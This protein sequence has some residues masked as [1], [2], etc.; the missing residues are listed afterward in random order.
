MQYQLKKSEIAPSAERKDL[1]PLV[2]LAVM[3]LWFCH[4]IVFS[5]KI[6]FFRDLATYFYPIKFSVAEAFRAGELP[7]WDRHMAT[8]FPIIAEFQSAVFYPPSISFYLLP[9]FAALRLTFVF[10]YALAASGAYILLRS[11]KSPAWVALI[12]AVLFA[13]GGTTVSLTNLLN[14]FQSAVW[15]PWII[16]FWERTLTSRRIKDTIVFAC[17][18]LCQLLGGSP[19]IFLLSLGLV[20]LDTLRL[21]RENQIQN[22]FHA[23]MVLL[24]AGLIIAGLGMVQLLPTAELAMQSRR[25]QAIP[26]GEA[27]AWSLQPSSLIGLL[28][29]TLEADTSLS[30]GVR[31]LLTDGVPFLLSHYMGVFGVLGFF[32]WFWTAPTKERVIV[33]AL[34]IISLV[35]A[36]G[37]HTPVYPLFY[38]WAP[39]LRILRFPEKYFYLTFALLIFAILRGLCRTTNGDKSRAPWMF[40]S[41]IFAGWL[42][43]YLS[44]RSHPVWLARMLHPAGPSLTEIN[45]A[46]LAAILVVLEKQVA[47]SLALLA[48]LFLQ[49]RDLLR[50]VLFQCLLVSTVFFDL[51]SANQPLHFL[52]DEKLIQNVSRVIEKPPVDPARLFY[53]P[54]GNNLHPAFMR[55]IGNPTYEKATEI[56]FNNLLPNAGLLYGFDY[57]QDIDALGR[58]SYTDLLNFINDLPADRRGKLLSALNVKYVIAFHDLDVKGLKLLREFPEHYSRMYEVSGSV[59]RA[60]LVGR[61]I[62]DVDPMNT[63]RR[64][65]SDEFDPRREVVLNAPTHQAREGTIDGETKITH[66]GNQNVQIEARVDQ[67]GVLVLTDAFY[68]G[69]K[70]FVDGTEQRV[71]RANYLFRAVELGA[72]NHHVEFVYDPLSFK[73]G[74]IISLVTAG[75]VIS[76]SLASLVQRRKRCRQLADAVSTEPAH[77]ILD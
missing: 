77:A 24:G 40:A 52:R 25:D 17:A 45:P 15:L 74:W 33:M 36:F 5:G 14:H 31:L 72:G 54:P 35:L 43:V 10:H 66:Y 70:V 44:F 67:P 61:T 50:P 41:M 18:A 46:T 73:I 32:C 63:L 1:L 65:V 2:A 27:L 51:S 42:A 6:P 4:E 28:L 26:M 11:W 64:L 69:W 49:W 55:V 53:Y 7:L 47:V 76:I 38:D 39:P 13:F 16:F 75:I 57:F 56:A 48:L 29:P 3:T 59:P 30:M 20:T 23:C 19:E 71:L 34:L 62:Y 37:S 68:P 21:R 22:V 8:G 60:Y 9:F 12:G 58:R